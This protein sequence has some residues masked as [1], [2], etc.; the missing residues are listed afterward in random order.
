MK[1]V[2]RQAIQTDTGILASA[3]DMDSESNLTSFNP[4]S[5]IS[6]RLTRAMSKVDWDWPPHFS[7]ASVVKWTWTRLPIAA[8]RVFDDPPKWRR[9][10]RSVLKDSEEDTP[11]I[12]IGAGGHSG[13]QNSLK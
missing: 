2:G 8:K 11:L 9:V 7:L 3:F 4:L 1:P 13:G 10:M 5:F 6:W 12:P